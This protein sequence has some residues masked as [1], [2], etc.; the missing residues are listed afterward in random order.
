M[1]AEERTGP[2][3]V[4]WLLVY[5]IILFAIPSRLVVDELGSAGAPSMLLG[6]ASFGGWALFQLARS[7][8][9]PTPSRAPVRIAAVLFLL[10]VA[11]SYIAAMVR[12][13]DGDEV[14]PADVALLSVVSWTGVLLV[15]HDG[16]TSLRRLAELSRILAWAAAALGIL[17]IA[18]FLTNDV[19]VD[20]ISIPGLRPAELEVF[21]RGDFVRPSGTATHPIEFGV[22]LTMLL[23][24]ALHNAAYGAGRTPLIRWLPVPL[25]AASI[26]LTFSRSAYVS[27]FAAIA[28]LLLGWP[29]QR[30]RGFLI[31]MLV[32]AAVLFA[33]VP[34]LFGTIGSLFRNVG[35]DPSI[36]SRTDSYDLFW[37]FF[38][39]APLVGRGLGTFLP[40]YR[41]LD[42]QYLMLLVGLGVLGTLAFLAMLTVAAVTGLR[43]SRRAADPRARDLGLSG[44]AALC[45]GG[46][47][48]ATFDGFAFPMTMG[49]LF[50]VAGMMGAL[51]RLTLHA[52]LPDLGDPV[53]EVL[54][55]RRA[56]SRGSTKFSIARLS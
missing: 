20:V 41:I 17:G 38:T 28:V 54:P 49:A 15:A 37:E 52:E 27:V 11:V 5:T 40:K 51:R 13:I 47:A 44:A 24:L 31:G 48:L 35:N 12:P 56:Q 53:E 45:A 42:N 10:A 39:Q 29:A 25:L 55:L 33:A 19:L 30:R 22:I 6:L 8:G 2:D 16:I 46:V 18:Q 9:A 4:T 1:N 3:A 36:A 43:V 26:A 14:S 50:L 32:M 21:A 23:P 7:S 34:R